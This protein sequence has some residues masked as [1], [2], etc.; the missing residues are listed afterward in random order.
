MIILFFISFIALVYSLTIQ[1]FRMIKNNLTPTYKKTPKYKAF[2][3][4]LDN[5][6]KNS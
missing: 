4:D 1:L 6:I 5:M 2:L 3:K